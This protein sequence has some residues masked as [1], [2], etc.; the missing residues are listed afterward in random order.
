M[1]PMIQF[2]GVSLLYPSRFQIPLIP[3][4]RTTQRMDHLWDQP[5]LLMAMSHHVTYAGRSSNKEPNRHA[6][7]VLSVL[8]KFPPPHEQAG[9]AAP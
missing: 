9:A 8:T 7:N 5:T 2:S 3:S 6:T 4:P 1:G